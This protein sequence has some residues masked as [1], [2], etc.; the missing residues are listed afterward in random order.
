MHNP[1]PHVSPYNSDAEEEAKATAK[2]VV[3]SGGT[4]LKE[5]REKTLIICGWQWGWVT[6]AAAMGGGGT[7]LSSSFFIP[8]Q[9]SPIQ[10]LWR[11]KTDDGKGR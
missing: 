11:S 6:A 10:Q 1:S 4:F 2:S 3:S 8:P 5:D 7:A 9:N